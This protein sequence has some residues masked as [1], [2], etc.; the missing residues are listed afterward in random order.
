MSEQALGRGRFEQVGRVLEA[1]HGMLAEIVD[2]QREIELGAAVV[3]VQLRDLAAGE[4]QRRPAQLAVAEHGLHQRRVAERALRRDRPDDLSER[5][6][7]EAQHLDQRSAH[8]L[9][10]LAQAVA[11]E[12]HARADHTEVHQAAERALLC[13]ATAQRERDTDAELGLARVAVQQQLVHREPQHERGDLELARQRLECLPARRWQ[14]PLQ[15]RTGVGLLRGPRVIERKVEHVWHVAELAPV[16]R[17]GTG[18]VIRRQRTALELGARLTPARQRSFRVGP[19]RVVGRAELGQQHAPE[20]PGVADHVVR[21]EH[22]R[23]VARAVHPQHAAK[24]RLVFEIE[25]ESHALLEQTGECSLRVARGFGYLPE[26]EAAL[27]PVQ[28]PLR[29]ALG[30]GEVAA[31]RRM[32]PLHQLQCALE[33]V[34]GDRPADAPGEAL[35]VATSCVGKPLQEPELALHRRERL[36]ARGRLAR[37]RP[38]RSIQLGKPRDRRCA[39]ELGQLG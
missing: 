7:V 29:L 22:Q 2:R 39:Q 31:Q 25:S 17:G 21:A 27:S 13:R 12:I 5:E 3:H 28:P 8:G 9:A 37:G 16:V 33:R 35:V 38:R 20:R 36:H 10:V 24:R 6:S 15:L 26:L 1:E 11:G 19:Q 14:L 4:G 32:A 34:E 18:R 30:R 23:G